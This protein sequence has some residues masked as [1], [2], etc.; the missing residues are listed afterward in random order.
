[1]VRASFQAQEIFK[2]L[3][4]DDDDDD[5]DDYDWFMDDEEAETPIDPI[6]PFIYFSDAMAGQYGTAA[7]ITF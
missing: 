2:A 7:A 6:D 1:M 3:E 4:N 5:D